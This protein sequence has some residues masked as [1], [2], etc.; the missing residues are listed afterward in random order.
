[1]YYGVYVT[2]NVFYSSSARVCCIKIHVEMA[3]QSQVNDEL[4]LAGAHVF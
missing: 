2:R 4:I 1:M 3:E